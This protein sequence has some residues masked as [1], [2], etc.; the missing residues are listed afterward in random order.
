MKKDYLKHPKDSVYSKG[1]GVIA[2]QAMRDRNLSIEAKAIYA[3]MC[4]YA[5]SGETAFPSVKRMCYD[6]NISKDRYYNH[7][8]LLT[9]QGYI[10][11]QRMYFTATG[12]RANNTYEIVT[13]LPCP[14]DQEKAGFTMS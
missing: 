7:L 3:Y 6:L 4:S 2:K 5:G 9:D 8:K 1:Y 12:Q 13:S 14:D 11:V 10:K